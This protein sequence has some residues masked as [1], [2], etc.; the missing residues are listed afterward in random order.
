[1][2]TETRHPLERAAD[3][4]LAKAE[5]MG[6]HTA[7][8][9]NPDTED[10]SVHSAT[11]PNTVYTVW[12]KRPDALGREPTEKQRQA[13][14]GWWWFTLDCNCPAITTSGYAVCKHKACV[15]LW[16]IRYQR[17][18]GRE[19]GTLPAHSNR[20]A[21]ANAKHDPDGVETWKDKEPRVREPDIYCDCPDDP[22]L[23]QWCPCNWCEEHYAAPLAM[24]GPGLSI[25]DLPVVQDLPW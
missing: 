20:A 10:W 12:R 22:C 9:W 23:E 6:G 24:N 7:A 21:K 1:M 3:G 4:A 19:W 17:R 15:R 11:D 18:D 25:N 14:R 2:D 13:N 16:Q 8:H 5:A